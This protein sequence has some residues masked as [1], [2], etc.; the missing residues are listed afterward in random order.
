[1]KATLLSIFS[2]ILLV[3]KADPPQDSSW[4][5]LYFT[6]PYTLSTGQGKDS[7]LIPFK[8]NDKTIKVG[9][10]KIENNKPLYVR[11]GGSFNKVFLDAF[12][13]MIDIPTSSLKVLVDLDKLVQQG[14]Y[15]TMFLITASADRTESLTISFVRAAAEVS[16]DTPVKITIEE[17]I[18]RGSEVRGDPIVLQETGGVSGINKLELSTP[19]F[20]S[21]KKAGLLK[22]AGTTISL[23]ANSN[24][25]LDYEIDGNIRGEL[26]IGEKTTGNL[27]MF[28]PEMA[29]PVN[30]N[31]EVTRIRSKKLIFIFVFLGVLFGFLIKRVIAGRIEW[32]EKRILAGQLLATIKRESNPIQDPDYKQKIADATANLAQ[33]VLEQYSF[34]PGKQSLA[35][36]ISAENDT[37]RTK[38]NDEKAAFK[39][40]FDDAQKELKKLTTILTD[41][42]IP[43]GLKHYLVTA[44]DHYQQASRAVE[45]F[46]AKS[47]NENVASAVKAV[48]SAL[49]SFKDDVT[50]IIELVETGTVFPI[51]KPTDVRDDIKALITTKATVIKGKLTGLELATID[52]DT[53][54][55]ALKNAIALLLNMKQM[56]E[57][58]IEKYTALF[59][60]AYKPDG[61]TAMNELNAAFDAWK[62][63]ITGFFTKPYD[64]GKFESKIVEALN[65]AWEKVITMREAT[66]TR[67]GDEQKKIAGI[68]STVLNWLQGSFA[69]VGI[70]FVKKELSS[71]PIE[72][73]VASAKT[74]WFWLTIFK[75]L[76]MIVLLS[77]I[78]YNIY[79]A[80]YKG[81]FSE[82]LTIFI[83]AFSLD[84]TLENVIGFQPKP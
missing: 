14:T 46:N 41:P 27:K 30:V 7:I 73:A 70:S 47:I 11:K 9:D 18:F 17:N 52:I 55:I 62:E 49:N 8:I 74:G 26:G 45:V 32:Q 34:L 38:Y 37:L 43:E 13:A 66:G 57:A 42:Q 40:T 29:T 20:K 69:T 24:K 44:N 67:W 48:A 78:A 3:G 50:N 63:A 82:L 77:L 79:Q 1:M 5:S 71:D 68:G 81:S 72:S 61:S 56:S 75:T 39:T 23:P 58:L 28:A 64:S 51:T 60:K 83:A 84:M 12:Q 36:S 59:N 54:G 25:Q 80:D 4:I 21:V 33:L 31:F 35:A 76:F 15:E 2:L 19:V 53:V 22:F 6:S 10:L 65:A 16:V